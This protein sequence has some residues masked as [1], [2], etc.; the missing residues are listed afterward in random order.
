MLRGAVSRA[1]DYDTDSCHDSLS[2]FRRWIHDDISQAGTMCIYPRLLMTGSGERGSLLCASVMQ[3]NTGIQKR[4]KKGKINAK[5]YDTDQRLPLVSRVLVVDSPRGHC[6]HH[7]EHG[8][9]DGY[10]DS[11]G[12]VTPAMCRGGGTL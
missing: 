12:M 7:K 8:S 9:R 2:G 5:Q 6:G 10:C 1:C 3:A 11:G 4:Q